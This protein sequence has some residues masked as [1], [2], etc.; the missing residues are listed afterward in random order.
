MN[1]FT[2]KSSISKR[3]YRYIILLASVSFL[4]VITS[5]YFSINSIKQ[6]VYDQETLA[7]STFIDESLKS[8]FNVGLTNA[9]MLAQ[10]PNF[11]EAL[12]NQDRVLAL[13]EAKAIMSKFKKSTKYKN[14]KIHIHDSNVHSFLRAWKPNKNGDDL[15]GFRNTIVHVKKTKEPLVAVEVG[16][17]GPTIRGLAPI[18]KD[19]KYIGSVEFMQGFNSIIKDSKKII[20]SSVLVLLN[21]D[22]ESIA[23]FF[24]NRQTLRVAGLLVAQKDNTIDKR[25]VN[26]ISNK[27]LDEI[28]QGLTTEHY[29]IR[30]K[31]LK[32]FQDNIIG[33]IVIGKD[34]KIVDKTIDLSLDAF[35]D[36]FIII[37]LLNMLMLFI[38]LF[39]IRKF[40]A[41][42]LN[43]LIILVKDLASSGSKDLTK[44]LLIKTDDEMGEVSFY[45]NKF[46]SLVQD[47]TENIKQMAHKNERLSK[48]I[49][50]KANSLFK[51]ADEQVNIVKISNDLTL[52]AT[53]DISKTKELAQI[54]T[55]NV[56]SSYEVLNRLEDISNIVIELV[57]SNAQEEHELSQKINSLVEQTQDIQDIL[58]IIKD[59][60]D[61]TNLLALNAAIEAARAGEHGRGFAVVADEVRKLAE[62]TQHSINNINATIMVVV[63]NVQNISEEMDKESIEMTDLTQKSSQMLEILNRS[64]ESS[65][66]MVDA[67]KESTS[68][69]ISI[70]NKINELSNKMVSILKF[71]NDTDKLSKELDEL[72]KVLEESSLELN[73]KLDEFKTV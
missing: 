18:F 51:L 71:A 28:L 55:S 4:I 22:V 26:E 52:K 19:K 56:L 60:A 25:F 49:L 73:S 3:V 68:K 31:P 27:S 11:I 66:K 64:K 8:K 59:I 24:K 63:Q 45:I 29:F 58:D 5:M 69:T 34:L 65:L 23:K 53:D 37:V 36:Q 54:T 46:I 62:K 42:P 61:Q 38:V 20:Q 14:I 15:S 30:V 2:K 12:F 70:D 50:Q 1:E 13:K 21:K 40:V 72:G 41:E 6:S 9:I 67:S 33:Y 43:N 17:A 57:S 44:R 48:D 10:N 35:I 39:I 16:R 47:L 7:M 32:D